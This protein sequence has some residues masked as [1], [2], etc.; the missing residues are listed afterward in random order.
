MRRQAAGATGGPQSGR[1]W[2]AMPHDPDKAP[3]CLALHLAYLARLATC[4]LTVSKRGGIGPA[5]QMPI[6]PHCGWYASEST[7]PLFLA[8]NGRI[9]QNVRAGGR[10]PKRPLSRPISNRFRVSFCHNPGGVFAQPKHH[11]A[12][13]TRRI[14]PHPR[15]RGPERLPTC[16]GWGIF[17]FP[18]ARHEIAQRKADGSAAG[19]LRSHTKDGKFPHGKANRLV[20]QSPRKEGFGTQIAANLEAKRRKAQIS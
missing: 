2:K 13:S 17:F 16:V 18:E 11:P 12:I 6:Y 5:S 7:M 10:G 4:P 8:D 9:G 14:G 15:L 19:A 3:D 1:W 20:R